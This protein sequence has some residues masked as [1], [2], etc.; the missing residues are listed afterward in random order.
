MRLSRCGVLLP[1][2]A[3]QGHDP[4]CDRTG[5]APRE[6]LFL[7]GRARPPGDQLHLR[8]VQVVHRHHVGSR[9]C[10]PRCAR[11][12]DVE[13][14]PGCCRTASVRARHQGGGAAGGRGLDRAAAQ[15]GSSLVGD[16]HDRLGG[17][18]NARR[19]HGRR[20]RAVRRPRRGGVAR[21]V[22]GRH[23]QGRAD[24]RVLGRAVLRV[25][26]RPRRSPSH[27]PQ[28]APERRGG[29]PSVVDAGPP[30]I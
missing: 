29:T 13:V 14:V 9:L 20:G 2:L 8:R 21:R 10:A 24:R 17:E 25:R 3:A 18:R 6:F 27:L 7:V 30:G 19:G 4:G 12:S 15:R 26:C 16:G 1:R 23:R 11:A 28:V 5:A 22:A